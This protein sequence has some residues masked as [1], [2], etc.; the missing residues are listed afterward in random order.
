MHCSLREDSFIDDRCFIDDS[1]IFLTVK[2]HYIESYFQDVNN[3]CFM[4]LALMVMM[5]FFMRIS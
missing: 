2:R 5:L 4:H 3:L 1:F